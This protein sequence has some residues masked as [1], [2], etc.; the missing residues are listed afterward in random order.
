MTSRSDIL[1]LVCSILAYSIGKPTLSTFPHCTRISTVVG[2][3]R[4][5]EVDTTEIEVMTS[6]SLNLGLDETACFEINVGHRNSSKATGAEVEDSSIWLYAV[7]YASLEQ[8]HPIKEQYVFS[9]PLLK[10]KCVCDC[11]GGDTHCTP[12]SHLRNCSLK[13][14]CVSTFHP[15]QHSAG[16]QHDGEATVC[17]EVIISPYQQRRYAAIYLGQSVSVASFTLTKFVRQDNMWISVKDQLIKM[18]VNQKQIAEYPEERMSF[19]VNGITPQWQLQEGMYFY[20]YNATAV[21]LRT[22]IPI[23]RQYEWNL[24][25]LGWF[26]KRDNQWYIRKGRMKIQAA[27]FVQTKD[28]QV[29]IYSDSYN[30]EFYVQDGAED[31]MVDDRV[32]LGYAVEETEKWIKKID[33]PLQQSTSPEPERYLVLH[34]S[35][36]L[37]VFLDLQLN[38]SANVTF[39]HHGPSIS[40]FRATVITD[41]HSNTYIN[42]TM[43]NVQGTIIGNLYKTDAEEETDLVFSTHVGNGTVQNHTVLLPVQNHIASA[44]WLCMHPYQV[45]TVKCRWISYE[46]TPLETANV[47]Y[48]WVQQKGDCKDC[49]Q[50]FTSNFLKYL[51]PSNWINGING[52][53]EALAVGMEVGLYVLTAIAGIAIFK[54]LVL[55]LLRIVVCDFGRKSKTSAT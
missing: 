38:M 27:H 36:S 29:Q 54:R 43:F 12:G 6:V 32:H 39:H 48:R 23:N 7:R 4:R 30:A 1:L 22:G 31:A 51:N 53:T 49:N 45:Q 20:E 35:L 34:H 3:V 37:A 13:P 15:H 11:P 10:S 2:N 33:I 47:P 21:T 25:K 42:L 14:F 50:H 52:W 8:I 18:I 40:D 9:V 17:C 26:R 28:C 55:P 5:K 16:C 24:N 44:R 41:R 46:S 19:V